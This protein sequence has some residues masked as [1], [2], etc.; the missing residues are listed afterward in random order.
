MESISY[1]S[2]RANLKSM[3]DKVLGDR[4]PLFVTRKN[5][6]EVVIIPRADYESL[7]ETLHLLS[8]RANAERLHQSITD[9]EAGNVISKSI[10][11]LDNMVK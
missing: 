3:L 9:Y 5:S 6:E 2:F 11:E 10:D 1:S 7:K 8:S 4:I